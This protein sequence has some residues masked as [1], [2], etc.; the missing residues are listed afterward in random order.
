MR[1]LILLPV[2]SALNI[3]ISSTDSWVS[4]NS[5]YIFPLLKEAGHNVVYVGPLNSH[6]ADESLEDSLLESR[7]LA[8][9]GDFNHLMETHQEYYKYMRKLNSVPRGAKN[10]LHQKS[11]RDFDSEFQSNKEGLV[12]GIT[13]GQDPLNERF[14]YVNGTPLEALSVAFEIILPKQLPGFTPDLVLLGPNEGLHLTKSGD[15]S[16]AGVSLNDLLASG[17]EL[18]SMRLLAQLKQI[19]VISVSTEDSHHIYYENE[20][21]FNVEQTSYD[22]LF[23]TNTITKNIQFVNARVVELIKKVVPNMRKGQALNVNFPSINEQS[24]TCYTNGNAGPNFEQIAEPSMRGMSLGRIYTMP[25]FA[26][27]TKNVRLVGK[28]HF[29]ASDALQTIQEISEVELTRFEH[30]FTEE[31][32]EVELGNMNAAGGAAAPG[33]PKELESLELCKIAVAVCDLAQGNNLESSSLD[34]LGLL[35]A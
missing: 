15:K 1:F 14:W 24:S 26:F 31:D 6:I 3:L 35:R 7:S 17:D 8:V 23:K 28:R 32:E 5:R 33:N 4:K 18:E 25:S 16:S 19:P 11:S 10:L 22:K 34:V 30:L 2:V 27:G 13:Y 29:K 20:N 12:S 9:H 21:F